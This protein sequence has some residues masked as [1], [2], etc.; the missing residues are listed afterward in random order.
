MPISVARLGWSLRSGWP[1]HQGGMRMRR[2]FG[3]PS[4]VDAEH[5]PQ[6]PLVPVGARPQAGDGGDR[7][8]VAG[9]GDLEPHVLVPLVGEQVIDH[10]EVGARLALARPARTRSSMPVRSYK[11]RNGPR[12]PALQVVAAPA[13]ASSRA[14]PD[15][16]DAVLGLLADEAR[17]PGSAPR[18]RRCTSMQLHLVRRPQSSSRLL[19]LGREQ[20]AA[21]RPVAA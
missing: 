2:R 16:G 6:L 1:S 12:R 20:V 5:V 4:T 7:R 10:R 17:P 9:E 11:V 19:P 13:S 18:A 8:E 14:H 21:R 15:G 3:W